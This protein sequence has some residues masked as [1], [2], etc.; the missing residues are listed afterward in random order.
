M[1]EK[2][3]VIDNI[4]VILTGRSA[5]KEVGLTKTE[6]GGR[7]LPRFDVLVEVT[8]L[9]KEEGSWKKWVRKI[10]LYEVKQQEDNDETDFLS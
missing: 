5:E 4:E 3:Y 7:L 10:D 1:A 9:D 6:V 2:T 8:P